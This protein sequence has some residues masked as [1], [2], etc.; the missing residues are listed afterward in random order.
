LIVRYGWSIVTVAMSGA[1]AAWLF[2]GNGLVVAL[3]TAVIQIGLLHWYL[4]RNQQKHRSLH[5]IS[6]MT[7]NAL[8]RALPMDCDISAMDETA[9]RLMLVRHR[10]RF[11]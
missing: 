5:A 11:G 9:I 6:E 7:I 4:L 8:E 3:V 2:G 10:E 1:I